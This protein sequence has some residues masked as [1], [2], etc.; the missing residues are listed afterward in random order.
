MA[1]NQETENPEKSDKLEALAAEAV[2]PP[3]QELRRHEDEVGL[4]LSG[5]G[6]RA[7]LFGL[8]TLWRLNDCGWLKRLSRITSVSGGS[9][10]SA[11]LGMNWRKLAFDANGVAQNFEP[12]IARPLEHF[13]S[14]HIDV[15]C[16]IKGMLTPWMT[17]GD[18]V[19][20][21]Y[22]HELYTL[23]SGLA[24][25]LQDLPAE[26]EGPTFILYATNL[27]TGVSVRFTREH[28]YDWRLGQLRD[29]DTTLAVAVGAS[30]AFPPVLSPVHLRTDPSRWHAPP[31]GPPKDLQR[32]RARMILSDGGVYD[33]LGVEAI[34]A[35]CGTVLVSDAGAPGTVVTSPWTNWL[36]Q[37][38]RVRS[39]MMEQTR[40]LRRRMIMANL[41]SN[42]RVSRGSLWRIGTRIDRFQLP[43][44]MI[45]DNEITVAQQFVRTRLNP[46]T[47]KEQGHLIN[48]G[49]ALCDAAMRRHVDPAI[50]RGQWPKREYLLSNE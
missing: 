43:D 26:G 24:A 9:I 6:F 7:A 34:F 14:L 19:A 31:S 12:L 23:D 50:R 5:G 25:T 3:P 47:P 41:T 48:W 33:N 4:A 2:Q 36:G 46:L 15:P 13:C 35:R 10:T 45:H 30:S 38:A 27:Q 44:A 29:P 22:K 11:Y 49:Y 18:F 17:A 32:L 28:I 40:A 21:A 1:D 37:L 39:I 8:G 42:P 16:V 20:R